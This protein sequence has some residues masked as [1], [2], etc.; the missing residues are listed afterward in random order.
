[1]LTITHLLLATAL[2]LTAVP[3]LASISTEVIPMHTHSSSSQ[4]I[5]APWHGRTV[6]DLHRQY[7]NIF[8]YGNRNA[9]SHRWSTFLLE[10]ARSSFTLESLNLFFSGFCAISGSPISP[11]DFNRYGL[12]LSS[13]TGVSRKAFGFM[14]YCCWP[15]VCDTQDFLKVDTKNVTTMDGRTHQLHFVVIGNPCDHPDELNKPFVQPFDRRK[16]TL[17]REAAEVRCMSDGTLEGATMSD[18]GFVIIGMFF[19]AVP[20]LSGDSNSIIPRRDDVTE[21]PGRVSETNT[22][23]KYQSEQEYSS[24]CANRARNGYNSGMGEIFRKVAAISKIDASSFIGR[25]DSLEE[26]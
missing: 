1:M 19:D 15:C 22:G 2:L 16:T 14:H 13:V 20:V 5:T 25:V 10:R 23:T 12:E 11:S 17:A 24:M 18:H 26:L 21:T 9:A 3:S 6:R 8:K 7:N 4:A